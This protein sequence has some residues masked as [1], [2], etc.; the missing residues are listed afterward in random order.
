MAACMKL[1]VIVLHVVH[2]P[3]DMP[4]YYAKISKKKTLVRIEDLA[5]EMFEDFMQGV[6]QRHPELRI[7]QKSKPMLALGLPVT[8]ILQVIEKLNA[9]MVVMGSQG[10][11]GLNHVLLG[12]KAEQI[13]RLSPVPVT[14]VK[15]K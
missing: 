11:T 13:V 3:G 1:P 10:R 15:A 9:S 4:G 8:K 2:D 6:K 12:S 5:M 14:I 7:L